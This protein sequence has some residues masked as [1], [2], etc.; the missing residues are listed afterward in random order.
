MRDGWRYAMEAGGGTTREERMMWRADQAI[1]LLRQPETD[2][3]PT[4]ALAMVEQLEASGVPV[5]A[6]ELSAR[7]W[8]RALDG[9]SPGP[10]PPLRLARLDHA[11]GLQ[12]ATAPVLAR[13]MRALRRHV[14]TATDLDYVMQ[15]LL[16]VREVWLAMTALSHAE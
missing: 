12:V 3:R 8:A 7:F 13:W 5:A 9:L 11:L 1:E 4:V 15:F 6:I 16:Q 2:E 14:T 10:V